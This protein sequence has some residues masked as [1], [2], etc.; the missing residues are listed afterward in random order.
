MTTPHQIEKHNL[1]QRA[2]F[3]S[4]F[5]RTMQPTDSAYLNR[6]VEELIRFARLEPGDRILDVGCGIGRYTLLLAARGFQIEGLDLSSKL[7]EQLREHESGN[8]SIPLHCSDIISFPEKTDMSYDAVIGFFT[9][10]HLHDLEA[11]Y[12]AMVKLLQ[13][14]GRIVFLEPN[15]F[16][17]LYYLQILL[18]PRMT[19]EGDGGIVKMRRKV[20]LPIME[21]QGLL[22]CRIYRFGFFPPFLA[23]RPWG[24][25]LE[26]V[27]ESIPIWRGCLPFQ[28]F[29][30]E[31]AGD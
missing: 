18:T 10:H 8:K 9:L 1:Q 13:P 4:T 23:N 17:P 16:N 12:A 11:S 29:Y 6:Q 27:L 25:R 5:K 7:L 26:S 14:G 30:G 24:R 22:N 28:I 19:W 21:R 3:E 15:A 2:Y 31:A 20:L